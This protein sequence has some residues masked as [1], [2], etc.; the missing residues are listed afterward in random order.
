LG[1]VTA[2]RFGERL[3]KGIQR[4]RAIGGRSVTEQEKLER[5]RSIPGF[6]ELPE[7]WANHLTVGS[8]VIRVAGISGGRLDR[9]KCLVS[10]VGKK[11][12]TLRSQKHGVVM[13]SKRGWNYV[14]TY[15]F[16]YWIEREES[17]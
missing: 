10:N 3:G 7:E 12:L 13:V 8:S 16:F 2:D 4:D 1:D 5:M 17:A 9:D 15:N 14:S 11:M 6:T